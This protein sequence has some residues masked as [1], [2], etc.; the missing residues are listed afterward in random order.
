MSKSKTSNKP[1]AATDCGLLIILSAPSGCGKTTLLR[2]IGRFDGGEFWTTDGVRIGSS[3]RSQGSGRVGILLQEAPVFDHLTVW[4]NLVLATEPGE[5]P[6]REFSGAVADLLGEFGLLDRASQRAADL[7]G[8][9][10]QRLAL[11]M[12]LASRPA[13]LL[14]DEPFGALDAITRRRL[15]EFYNKWVRGR[16][17]CLFVTHDVEEALVVG[18]QVIVGVASGSERIQVARTVEGV[19]EWE[20]SPPFIELRRRL[21]ARLD[22]ES[23]DGSGE[24]AGGPEKFLE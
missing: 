10:R 9:Q 22:R 17:T 1:A 21:L 19:R 24:M 4:D 12:V 20:V 7:S 5:R 23:P 13:L 11:A 6:Q 16:V 14:L 8:G 3:G 15:Q 18:D 2:A